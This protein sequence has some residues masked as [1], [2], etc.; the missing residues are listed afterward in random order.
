MWNGQVLE[1]LCARDENLAN[2]VE[3]M[4]I[5][6]DS[7]AITSDEQWNALFDTFDESMRMFEE[8]DIKWC[9]LDFALFI[10]DNFSIAMKLISQFSSNFYEKRGNLHEL[11]DNWV[12]YAE[13]EDLDWV[14]VCVE[15]LELLVEE[16][17]Q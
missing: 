1:L 7:G 15:D 9:V 14:E 17:L 10:C 8:I 2:K 6:D 16:E 4:E 3:V 12:A 11:I 5:L 13:D